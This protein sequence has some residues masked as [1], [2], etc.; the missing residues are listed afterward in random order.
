[1]WSVQGHRGAPAE[2]KRVVVTITTLRTVLTTS[3]V[4]LL[5]NELLFIIFAL[6]PAPDA[7]T[8]EHEDYKWEVSDSRKCTVM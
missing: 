3:A 2:I 4:S 6:L 5:P 1:V 7:E 8:Y